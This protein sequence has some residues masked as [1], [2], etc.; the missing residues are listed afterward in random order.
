MSTML[1]IGRSPTF[2][3][4][5]ASQRGDGPIFTPRITDAVY[6]GHRSGSSITTLANDS[7]GGSDASY[8]TCGSLTFPP[9][10][11]A[12]SRAMPRM[13]RQ[14][15]LLGVRSRSSTVSPRRSLSGVPT[16]ASGSSTRMPSCSSL[17]P[18]SFSEHTIPAETTPRILDCFSR[19]RLSVCGLINSAPTDANAI[20]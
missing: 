8:V 20:F 14:S 7:I 4:R 12:T 11:A 1:L 19:A 3:R 15:G 10:R 6:L 13:D 16:E 2:S 17:R 18:S 9:V 5:S